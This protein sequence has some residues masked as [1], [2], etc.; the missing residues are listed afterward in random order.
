M[1]VPQ[2]VNGSVTGSKWKCHTGSGDMLITIGT[3]VWS[4]RVSI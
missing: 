3:D 1:E 2:K 4:G